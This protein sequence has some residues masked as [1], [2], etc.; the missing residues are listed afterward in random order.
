MS[1]K[2]GEGLKVGFNGSF[3]LEFHGSIVTSDAGLLPYRDL[4]E[5]FGLFDSVSKD[6][7]DVR[8]GRNIQHGIE[9]LLR[10]S[11]CSRLAGY[12]D[13]ND[14]T[15]MSEDPVMRTFSGKKKVSRNAASTNTMERFFSILHCRGYAANRAAIVG[16][17]KL[18]VYPLVL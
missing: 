7:S 11:V 5:A 8:T 12:E 17:R 16:I 4:D 15:Q 14:A 13:V 9:N 2:K 6:F 1:Q 3:R 10:Q 18:P